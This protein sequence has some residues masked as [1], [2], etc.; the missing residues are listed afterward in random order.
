MDRKS[1]I[2][3][4]ALT[5][6]EAS[7]LISQVSR[8]RLSS[9]NN[10]ICTKLEDERSTQDKKRIKIF[11]SV[12][13]ENEN[14]NMEDIL[15][16]LCNKDIQLLSIVLSYMKPTELQWL[17]K[18][19]FSILQNSEILEDTISK[20]IERKYKYSLAIRKAI[21]HHVF[22]D[23]TDDYIF[24]EN[25]ENDEVVYYLKDYESVKK[26][27]ANLLDILK[28]GPGFQILKKGGSVVRHGS[29]VTKKYP[30]PLDFDKG[31]E[32]MNRYKKTQLVPTIVYENEQDLTITSKYLEGYIPLETYLKL[33]KNFQVGKK[34]I[35]R[36]FLINL[37]ASLYQLNI[38]QEEGKKL[39]YEDLHGNI[40]NIGFKES[41]HSFVFYEGG[42]SVK[43][44]DSFQ[45]VLYE[46][47]QGGS[48]LLENRD[49]KSKMPANISATA[50]EVIVEFLKEKEGESYDR[51]DLGVRAMR[52]RK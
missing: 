49:F 47:F 48:N 9:E 30:R 43:Q 17:G 28:T 10:S 51:F 21:L 19:I 11:H 13:K 36:L 1:F 42:N 38:R 34:M 45:D 16:Q 12:L 52:K 33:L 22:E 3:K 5:H 40:N 35:P 15:V 39:D 14:E 41:D 25:K 18:R 24:K 26:V 23:I 29:Y 46:F 7:L 37:V 8:L 44:K 32:F 6:C 27:I 20:W 31:F 50:R 2:I 4:K